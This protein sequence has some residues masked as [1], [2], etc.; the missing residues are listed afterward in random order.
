MVKSQSG[1]GPRGFPIGNEPRPT[2]KKSE[3]KQDQE[4]PG[5]QNGA[6]TQQDQNLPRVCDHKATPTEC[7]VFG[8]MSESKNRNL[9]QKRTVKPQEPPVCVCVS[10]P[11]PKEC[12]VHSQG[13]SGPFSSRCLTKTLLI[14]CDMILGRQNHV[15]ARFFKHI[16]KG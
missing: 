6:R 8:A 3:T 13:G 11:V 5:S 16:V 14:G 2:A 15:P 7:L 10:T 9:R 12:V 1:R 4:E